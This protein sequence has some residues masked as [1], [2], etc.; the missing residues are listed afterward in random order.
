MPKES[1]TPTSHGSL[2]AP[3]PTPATAGPR[4]ATVWCAADDDKLLQARAAGLN[5]QPIANQYF[6]NKS[7]NA[8]RKR[9]E[10]LIE[11]RQASDWEA[12]KIERLAQEYVA[13]RKEMWE[14]LAAKMG[15]RWNVVE[16]KVSIATNVHQRTWLIESSAWRR[17][18]KPYWQR[19]VLQKDETRVL[20]GTPSTI[21]V[22]TTIT[23]TQ[24]WAWA[25][26][27][28]WS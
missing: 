2:V 10:R 22:L 6:P 16:A 25:R 18:S 28:R 14:A 21:K 20:Q 13:M 17:V 27:L 24:L 3:Y 11:R 7:A 9:Y 8:C 5:W 12:E 26:M 19:L 15:E 23:A 1:K 4:A